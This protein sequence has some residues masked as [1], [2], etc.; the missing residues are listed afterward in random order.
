MEVSAVSHGVELLDRLG[1]EEEFHEATDK[2]LDAWHF[3]KELLFEEPGVVLRKHD[4]LERR[5]V[6]DRNQS[7][8]AV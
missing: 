5:N 2:A 6:V 4:G 1:R 7:L 3:D 8:Q